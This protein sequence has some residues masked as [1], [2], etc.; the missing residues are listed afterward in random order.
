MYPP[1][2]TS[3]S[4]EL[5]GAI[6][7]SMDIISLLRWRQTC[8]FHYAQS[9]AALK[10]SLTKLVNPFLSHPIALLQLITHFRAVIGGEV[11][12][13]Y[14]LRDDGFQP[15]TL[16]IYTSA[17]YHSLLCRAMLSHPDI[18]ANITQANAINPP[19]QF[20]LQRDIVETLIISLNNGKKIYVHSSST[21][22]PLSP[23]ARATC[24]A[25]INYVTPESFGCGYPR[26]TLYQK[27]LQST[28]IAA[29]A[30]ELSDQDHRLT[31]TLRQLS[32]E[33]SV[34]PGHWQQYRMWPSDHDS[35]ADLGPCWRSHFIC[36]SQSRYF[37][38]RGSLLDFVDPLH[39]SPASLQAISAPPYGMTTVWRLSSSFRCALSCESHDCILPR[40]LISIVV[41]LILDPYRNTRSHRITGSV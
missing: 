10:R 3:L 30:D 12:L 39:G 28:T 33:T 9:T 38:D 25:L 29:H 26:L 22:S 15:K 20:K 2:K 14:I 16:E 23:V 31:Y 34:S 36:P 11:A 18:Y 4:P 19:Q 6:V 5:A 17:Y 8:K 35:A 7:D 24:T 32:I 21:A 1:F 37:G 40:G 27:S 13:A 41:H